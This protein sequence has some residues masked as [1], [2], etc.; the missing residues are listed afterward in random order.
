MRA[1][2]IYEDIKKAQNLVDYLINIISSGLVK[3]IGIFSLSLV[4]L[5][6]LKYLDKVFGLCLS[7]ICQIE[8]SKCKDLKKSMP[9]RIKI[10]NN[11]KKLEKAIKDICTDS[12]YFNIWYKVVYKNYFNR[13]YENHED[14]YGLLKSYEGSDGKFIDSKELLAM[15]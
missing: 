9:D 10:V 5:D 1:I 2:S 6:H 7:K 3:T 11:I 13:I 15:K 14:I 4:L 8:I 12:Q